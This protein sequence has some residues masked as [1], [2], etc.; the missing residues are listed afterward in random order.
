MRP[1]ECAEHK[2]TISQHALAAM[3]VYEETKSVLL[4]CQYSGF[5]PGKNPTVMWTRNDLDPTTVHVRREEEDDLKGQNWHYSG[6]TSMR[7]D[8]LD[9]G[10]FSLT[11]RTPELTDSG[12][13]T[14]TISDARKKLKLADIQLNVKGQQQTST[15]SIRPKVNS[16]QR[17]YCYLNITS[18]HQTLSRHNRRNKQRHDKDQGK[19]QTT[20]TQGDNQEN[21][22]T[23][24]KQVT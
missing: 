4:P 19:T 22:N 13:Y 14:C 9:T 2:F 6:R 24:G 20:N 23:W 1:R 3:V 11:L 7:P 15:P 16:T 10:D 5:I 8:A 18:K 21:G 17:P 12:K